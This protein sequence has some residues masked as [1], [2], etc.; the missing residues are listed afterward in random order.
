MGRWWFWGTVGVVCGTMAV[1]YY[2]SGY[3]AERA[4]GVQP[5]RPQIVTPE[6]A[7]D[8]VARAKNE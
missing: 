2:S 4:A 5:A 7:K 6:D 8:G 1:L 3:Y